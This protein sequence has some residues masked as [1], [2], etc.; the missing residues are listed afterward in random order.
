MLRLFVSYLPC[1]SVLLLLLSKESRGDFS[2][3]TSLN[4]PPELRKTNVKYITE[5]VRQ[6]L[7]LP[8][9]ALVYNRRK[10]YARAYAFTNLSPNKKAISTAT[11]YASFTPARA[12]AVTHKQIT[13]CG[14]KSRHISTLSL[15]YVYPHISTGGQ[16]PFPYS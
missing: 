9:Y 3:F 8:R 6:S 15:S 1:K 2:L 10:K 4:F 11:L 14:N 5:T 16:H 13:A 7:C 12:K